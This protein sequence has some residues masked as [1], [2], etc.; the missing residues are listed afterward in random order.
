[1]LVY[2]VHINNVLMTPTPH[3]S[4]QE[5]NTNI[6]DKCLSKANYHPIDELITYQSEKLFYKW[7]ILRTPL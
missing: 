1:M 3:V 7:F 6:L 5:N 4:S 2:N